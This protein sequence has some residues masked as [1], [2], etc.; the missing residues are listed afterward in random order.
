MRRDDGELDHLESSWTEGEGAM[1]R[2]LL[3]LKMTF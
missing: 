1:P 3:N 2:L